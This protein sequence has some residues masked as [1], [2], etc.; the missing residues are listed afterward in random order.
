MIAKRGRVGSAALLGLLAAACGGG[1][2]GSGGGGTP[3]LPGLER[4]DAGFFSVDKPIGWTVTTA[5]ACQTFAFL[6]QDPAE[7]LA[8][9][10]YFGTIGPV[11][12]TQAQKDFDLYACSFTPTCPIP[13]I[14]APVVDP[15][16]P[17]HFMAH[18]PDIADMKAAGAFM[19]AFPHL[20]GLR[21]ASTAAK[22]PMLQ[23]ASTGESR[24]IFLRG[25]RVGQGMFLESVL[26]YPMDLAYGHFVCGVTAPKPDFAARVDLL[27]A[28][29]DSF[30]VTQD[31]VKWCLAQ[32]QQQWGAV[33]EIGRTL[34]EASDIL[35]DG[36]VGRTHSADILAE[37][38]SDGFRGVERVYDPSSS[39][40]YEVPAGW[41]AD[42]YD[43]N[44]GQYQMS[45]LQLLPDDAW[46][47]WMAAVLSGSGI[48]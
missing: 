27:V 16:T 31:Y 9:V 20:E 14:D 33:A 34:S 1:G 15:F 8:Q 3:V 48:H 18:W 43:P 17:E 2:G 30:T 45:G 7:P 28:A 29:L 32:S 36:W 47:L 25:G 21:L 19:A 35:W 42:T 44:R 46:S 5:G 4:H 22:P 12:L 26:V 23:L 13:W 39:T 10:F 40:V 38:Y 24:G 6:L 41:Y 11:Y 37:Q